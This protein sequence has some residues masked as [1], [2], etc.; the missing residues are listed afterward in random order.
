MSSLPLGLVFAGTHLDSGRSVI[1]EAPRHRDEQAHDRFAREAQ[2]LVS[3][4]HPNIVSLIDVDITPG[5]RP[6]LVLERAPGVDLA[7]LLTRGPLPLPMLE[8]LAED[9]LR[10]LDHMHRRHMVHRDI[11]PANIMVGPEFYPD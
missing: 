1:L 4:D 7:S 3:C 8:R 11:K 9:L 6:I 10:A 5:G 2:A